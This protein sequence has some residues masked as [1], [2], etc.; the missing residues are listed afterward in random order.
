MCMKGYCWNGNGCI[1]DQ[2][3]VQRNVLQ[4]LEKSMHVRKDLLLKLSEHQTDERSAAFEEKLVKHVAAWSSSRT[5]RKFKGL[6][7][8]AE[9]EDAKPDPAVDAKWLC[10]E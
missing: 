8:E 9:M 7:I 3:F 6:F 1:K 2:D 10:V 5:L 4:N